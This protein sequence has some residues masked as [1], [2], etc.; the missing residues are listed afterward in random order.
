MRPMLLNLNLILTIFAVKLLRFT[1]VLANEQV[2]TIPFVFSIATLV[3]AVAQS[4]R[5]KTF[6]VGGTEKVL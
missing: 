6:V 4:S 5:R 2:G 1:H 3:D